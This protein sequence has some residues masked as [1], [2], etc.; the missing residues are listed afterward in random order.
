MAILPSNSNTTFDYIIAG[1]GTAGCV[2]A[3]RLRALLPESSI[4]LVEHGPD[5]RFH[6]HVI[7]PQAAPLLAQ[8]DLVV[9]YKTTSQAQ[10]NNRSLANQ[11]GRVLSGSSAINY[12]AWMRAPMADYDHWGEQ[13]GLSRWSY[14][15]LLPYFRR[16]EHH[17]DPNGDTEQHGFDGPFHTTSGRVYPLRET[18][19]QAF[20]QLGFIESTD[21]K[22]CGLAPWVENWRE[23]SRQHSGKIYD[24]S[25]VRLIINT[26]VSSITL[27][28]EQRATGVILQDGRTLTAK[29]EVIISCGA[30]KTPQLLM[31]SGIGPRDELKKHGISQRVH[32]PAVGL[33]HFDHLALH[34]AWKLR[35]PERGHA[36]GSAAFNKPEYSLGFPVEWIGSYAVPEDIPE[37]TLRDETLPVNPSASTNPSQMSMSDHAH[38]GLLVAYAPMNLAAAYDIP[39]DG[40][41]IASGVLLYQP[42]SRGRITLASADSS[43]EPTVD[44]NYYSTTADKKRFRDGVRRMAEFMQTPAAREMIVGETPPEG[45]PVLS[46]DSS[47]EDIDARIRACADVWHHSAG[48]A[49]MGKDIQNSVVDAELKVHGTKDL[50]VVDAS[51]FPSPISATPQATVYAIAELAAELIARDATE[52]HAVER[53]T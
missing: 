51:V 21:L 12:G 53:E 9:D 25:D 6:P 28:E 46:S 20:V 29:R 18:I 44:P 50:R 43:D 45:I 17:F 39:V 42:T 52:K 38:I 10:L 7:D 27:N 41:H 35:F 26:E 24:L 15:G 16:T 5:E 22:I 19:R 33:N 31:L 8:T 47:D 40:S 23:G 11:A 37:D 3:S 32:S 48:T 4:A 49:A 2:L 1:G 30:H 34:Q 13:V 14:S 36:V